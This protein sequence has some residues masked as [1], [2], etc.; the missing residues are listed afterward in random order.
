M[1]GYQYWYKSLSQSFLYKSSRK[2]LANIAA[3]LYGNP[4]K[5][6]F[7]IGVT[8]SN[9]KTTTSLLLHSIFNKLVGKTLV[10]T[11]EWIYVWDE[12]MN[13][14][15]KM[16]SYDPYTL[17]K[18]LATAKAD[19]CKIAIIEVSSHGLDQSRFEWV[20]FDVGVLTNLVEEHLDYHGTMEN[21]A[22][23]KKKLFSGIM[24]NSKNNK[25]AVFPKDDKYGRAWAEEF[26]FDRAM[27]FGVVSSATLKA[28]NV[29]VSHEGTS[30]SVQ[31]LGKEYSAS[32]KLLWE[33]NVYNVIAALSVAVLVGIDL[34]KAIEVVGEFS[35]VTGRLQQY[36]YNDVLYYVDYCHNADGLKNALQF[37]HKIKGNWRV[38]TMFGLAWNRDIG[39]RALAWQY[40]QEYSDVFVLTEDDSDTDNRF[41]IMSGIME[42]ISEKEWDNFFIIPE[43]SLAMKFMTDIAKPW[44]TVLIA[45]KWHETKLYGYYGI[46]KWNDMEELQWMTKNE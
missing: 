38:L 28:N 13:I 41:D 42:W 9:W 24:A 10:I 31:Y 36:K 35:G 39:Q 12:K 25:L 32:L 46:K 3:N 40:V 6:F 20:E 45:G 1:I 15:K 22:N 14:W 17:Q 16:T 27:S 44:D 37:L 11:T 5:D 19:W 26:S 4:S 33:Y 34:E 18:I 29:S 2:V 7:V 43:R 8:W 23:T 21:Y 30:F